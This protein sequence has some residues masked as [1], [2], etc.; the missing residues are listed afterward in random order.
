MLRK[1]ILQ[2][3]GVA[4]FELRDDDPFIFEK[5]LNNFPLFF[6]A[7]NPAVH[8]GNGRKLLSLNVD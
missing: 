4:S 3:F 6:I 7:E 1:Y 8:G 2:K 5:A